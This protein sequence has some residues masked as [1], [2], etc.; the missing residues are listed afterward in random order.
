MSGVDTIFARATPPGRAA[1][2]VLR[3]SGSRSGEVL[4]LLAGGLPAPRSASLRRLADPATAEVLDQAL[5]L[6][7]PGPASYT[8]EDCVEFHLHGGSAV[9]SAVSETLMR[10]GCRPAEP[11]E[12]TRRAFVNGKLD[13]LQAEAVADLID[14]ETT[15]Q[16]LQALRQ[17]DGALSRLYES[18]AE[19]ATRILAHMEAAIE[20]EMDDLPTDLAAGARHLAAALGSD[21]ARHLD[22]G[23]RGER[24]REGL[25]VAIL[26]APNAGKSSLLNALLGR[27]AA[28]VSAQAGT[29]RDVVE[30]RL[31]LGGIP[32]VIA[33]TAGLRDTTDEVEQEGVRRAQAKGRDADI[34][35]LVMP[36]DQLPDTGA[37]R[38]LA[39]RPDALLVL[40]KC[41]LAW[42]P[43]LVE[44]RAA[45]R[46][47]VRTG[48]G[49]EELRAVLAKEAERRA[50]LTEAPAPTRARHRAALNEALDL[51]H[52]GSEAQLPEV[53]AE[54]FRAALGA[55]G[56]L[57][58]RVDVETVLD[59]V[60]SEFCIGK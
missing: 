59:A 3:L 2:A 48:S 7:F 15:A 54:A 39:E 10:L 41:D 35:L 21:I 34:L 46:T 45:I 43:D 32:A 22:D 49:M 55:I 8:G 28:I 4:A 50:A 26:G 19:R 14:S 5:V 52:Q 51:L 40:S 23:S 42:G 18:W 47:S 36:A 17:A 1:I 16:R 29:T 9:I 57:T 27:P 24:L 11:G 20:F 37:L 12:F 53:A 56:R 13:L 60:F 44:G 25:S 31:D 58:G 30:G 33:D 6:W 38:L